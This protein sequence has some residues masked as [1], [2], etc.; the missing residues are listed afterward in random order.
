[1]AVLIAAA[2]EL[3]ELV[4][5]EVAKATCAAMVVRGVSCAV[6]GAL[7]ETLGINALRSAASHRLCR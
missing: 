5:L 7:P 3:T 2:T 6:T 1:M 4:A